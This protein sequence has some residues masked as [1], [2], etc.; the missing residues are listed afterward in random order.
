MNH[1]VSHCLFPNKPSEYVHNNGRHVSYVEINHTVPLGF[2]ISEGPL[3]ELLNVVLHGE[4]VR[5]AYVAPF[6]KGTCFKHNAVVSK[7]TTQIGLSNVSTI[8][9]ASLAVIKFPTVCTVQGGTSENTHIKMEAP[10]LLTAGGKVKIGTR[11][12]EMG[13]RQRER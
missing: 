6:T 13:G 12:Q 11:E 9:G 4:N 2:G 10:G 3:D 7:N 8:V 1:T 5:L